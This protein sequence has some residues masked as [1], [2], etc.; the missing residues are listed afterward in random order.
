LKKEPMELKV[1]RRLQWGKF[2]EKGKIMKI[3]DNKNK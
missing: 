1:L 3:R 2:N